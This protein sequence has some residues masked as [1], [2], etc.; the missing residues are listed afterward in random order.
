M[1]PQLIGAVHITY[2]ERVYWYSGLDQ[3]PLD[4]LGAQFDT[5]KGITDLLLPRTSSA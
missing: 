5:S 1:F 2:K 3:T 4:A